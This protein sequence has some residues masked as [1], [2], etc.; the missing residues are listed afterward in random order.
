MKRRKKNIE[1]RVFEIYFMIS[2]TDR[3]AATVIPTKSDVVSN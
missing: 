3:T 2:S 1:G